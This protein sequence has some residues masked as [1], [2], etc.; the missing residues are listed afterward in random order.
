MTLETLKRSK[1]YLKDNITQKE[2][3]SRVS[4]HHIWETE[5]ETKSDSAKSWIYK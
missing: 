2:K 4:K 5:Q 1:V 3:E